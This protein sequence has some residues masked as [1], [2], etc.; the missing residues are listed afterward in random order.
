MYISMCV[1]IY[2]YT[3]INCKGGTWKKA[4]EGLDF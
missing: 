2:I 3:Y 4:T 1:Y